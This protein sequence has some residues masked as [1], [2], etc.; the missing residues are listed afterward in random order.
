MQD[1]SK[2]IGANASDLRETRVKN[3]VRNAEAASRQKVEGAKQEFRN[4]QMQMEDILDLGATN[5]QDIATHLKGFDAQKFVDTIYPLAVKMAVKAR[6]VTIMVNLHNKLFPNNT[7]E[8]LDKDDLSVLE[9]L[10]KIGM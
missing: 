10:E 9:G 7:V 5:T 2:I 6:E 4:L 3:T 8:A 1:F